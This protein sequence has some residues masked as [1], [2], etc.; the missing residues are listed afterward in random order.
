MP[1]PDLWSAGLWP[2]GDASATLLAAVGLAALVAFA[3]VLR[4]RGVPGRA[5]RALV[6]VGTGLAVAAMPLVFTSARGPVALALAFAAVNAWALR[7]GRL[8]GLHDTADAGPGAS[9]EPRQSVGTVAFPLALVAGLLVVDPF[10]GD[11]SARAVWAAAFATLALADPLAA[12]VGRAWQRRAGASV[13]TDAETGKTTVGSAAFAVV[14]FLA[15]GGALRLLTPWSDGEVA[16]LA[17]LCAVVGTACERVGRGGWDNLWIVLGLLALGRAWTPEPVLWSADAFGL[18]DGLATVLHLTALPVDGRVHLALAVL[19]GAV[20]A[21]LSRRARFLTSGGALAA[22][23]LAATLV[24]TGSWAHALS[25]A[26]FFVLSSLLSKAGRRRAAALDAV[27]E[28]GSVRDAGQVLAN[29]GVAWACLLLDPAVAGVWGALGLW[30]WIGAFAAAAADT[31]ATEIGT[32]AGQRPRLIT[33]GRAVAPGTSGGITVAGTLGAAAGALTVGVLAGVGGATGAFGA[34]ISAAAP[35]ALAA[36]LTGAFLDSLLGATLQARY[37]R[38]D[39]TATERATE[40]DGRANTHT[41]GWQ[42]MTNDRVNLAATLA[43]AAVGWA[44]GG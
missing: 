7:R 29:G 44:M 17:A 4:R 35:V 2:Y 22:G 38:A 42:W 8:A 16:A 10:G 13:R 34:G 24:A 39:G 15:A 6:H 1:P 32:L 21:G 37:R 19:T 20:V 14:A 43:G 26:G 12:A 18:G 25:G 23:L 31:W 5:T 3:G 41:G 30:G 33:S 11:E 9:A 28:K 27:S 36:G 40:P